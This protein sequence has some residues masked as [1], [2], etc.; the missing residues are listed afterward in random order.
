MSC[1]SSVYFVMVFLRVAVTMVGGDFFLS[2]S[3]CSS[4]YFVMVFLRVAVTMVGGDF[5]L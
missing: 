5:F 1:C 2:M 4:V 3:C